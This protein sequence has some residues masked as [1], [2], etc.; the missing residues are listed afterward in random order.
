MYCE[1]KK[2]IGEKLARFDM[3]RDAPPGFVLGLQWWQDFKGGLRAI[4]NIVSGA[5]RV[6][7]APIKGTWRI[8]AVGLEMLEGLF[9][10]GPANYDKIMRKSQTAFL[11]RSAAY[12]E[13]DAEMDKYRQKPDGSRLEPGQVE[14]NIE[15]DAAKPLAQPKPTI[16]GRTKSF[17]RRLGLPTIKESFVHESHSLGFI[18]ENNEEGEEVPQAEIETSVDVNNIIDAIIQ[19]AQE[20]R[21]RYYDAVSPRATH[22]DIADFLRYVGRDVRDDDLDFYALASQT[23]PGMPEE[24]KRLIGRETIN[25]IKSDIM[26]EY[27]SQLE[28]ATKNSLRLDAQENLSDT[29]AL[30]LE[31]TIS[32]LSF[33]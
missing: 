3:A 12:R 22:S 6:I 33:K 24:E 18:L 28:N 11:E 26:P 30:R 14:K 2:L 5:W 8:G 15:K 13:R 29:E 1:D 20:V 17:I 10:S 19:D 32:S 4:S 9:T 7:M 23:D 31:P 21:S 16:R 27:I 25:M